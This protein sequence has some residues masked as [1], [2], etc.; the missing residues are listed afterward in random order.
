MHS[1]IKSI[2]DNYKTNV[3]QKIDFE[4]ELKEKL[5]VWN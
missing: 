2:V 5:F 3:A 4:N 1:E